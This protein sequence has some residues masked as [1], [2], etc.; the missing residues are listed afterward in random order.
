VAIKILN[1]VG[2]KLFPSALLARCLVAVRGAP[3]APPALDRDGATLSSTTSASFRR[4]PAASS[5]VRLR[6]EYV[7]WFL[8]AAIFTD[9]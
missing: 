4:S 9:R 1:P 3:V 8:G 7:L 6:P 5:R 2:Y